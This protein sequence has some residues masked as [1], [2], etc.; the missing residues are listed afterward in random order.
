MGQLHTRPAW[1][2]RSDLVSFRISLVQLGISL[3]RISQL[4]RVSFIPPA[5]TFPLVGHSPKGQGSRTQRSFS[6][7]PLGPVE[8]RTWSCRF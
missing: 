1:T 3:A 6:V 8:S 5:S 2:A 4:W 7:H